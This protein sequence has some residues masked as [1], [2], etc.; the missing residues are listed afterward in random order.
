MKDKAMLI[1]AISAVPYF[2][3]L[4]LKAP[5]SCEINAASL[6]C[7][8]GERFSVINVYMQMLAG[9]IEPCAGVIIQTP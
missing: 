4:P 5:L 9:A 3:L 7:L 1:Q 2:D 6:V 8:L